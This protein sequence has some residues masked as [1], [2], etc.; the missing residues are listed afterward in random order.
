MAEGLPEGLVTNSEA[1]TGDIQ[2]VD[3]IDAEDLAHLWRVYTTNRN[4]LANDV[5][6]RLENF[7]WRI[8]SNGKIRDNIRG[9]QIAQLFIAISEGDVVIRTTPT[10]SP[11]ASRI[12]PTFHIADRLGTSPTPAAGS[13]VEPDRSGIDE[14]VRQRP[15]TVGQENIGTQPPQPPTIEEEKGRRRGSSRPPPILKKPRTEFTAQQSKTARI[16]TPTWKSPRRDSRNDGFSPQASSSRSFDPDSTDDPSPSEEPASTA[17]P[18]HDA[19]SSIKS[20]K[21]KPTFTASSSSSKRRPTVPRRKSSQSSS[22][23]NT[24]KASSPRLGSQAAHSPPPPLP[25]LSTATRQHEGALSPSPAPP[26][27]S[28]TPL[29]PHATT[30]HR[31]PTS[32]SAS[33]VSSGPFHR[34]TRDHLPT[35]SSS[36][37]TEHAGARDGAHQDWL[38]DPHFRAK[39]ADRSRTFA[40]F[41]TRGDASTR[42]VTGVQAKGR[43]ELGAE[44]GKGMA[45][46]DDDEE[47][48]ERRE[49]QAVVDDDDDDDDDEDA[50]EDAEAAPVVQLPRT[51]SQLTMLLERDRRADGGEAKRAR[52]KKEKRK[53]EERAKKAPGKESG[54]RGGAR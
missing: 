50:I 34:P 44:K 52:G 10:S 29:S 49:E 9:T 36:S 47:G 42:M 33:P 21:K 27:P 13:L 5:G 12:L 23:N 1:I 7:F 45:E 30:P 31:R 26:T 32:R 46:A 17:S 14:R 53:E 24:S 48:R 22:S 11:R 6:R 54:R 38:V 25:P 35:H 16:L 2:G 37:A 51:K 43:F 39:F 20:S 3:H 18:A 19:P 15:V 4:L 41:P 8:W 40:S 28:D